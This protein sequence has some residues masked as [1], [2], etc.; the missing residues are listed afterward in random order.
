MTKMQYNHENGEQYAEI[1]LCN[2]RFVREQIN[3]MLDWIG[4]DN[5]SNEI[6]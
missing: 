5:P 3:S 6:G 4:V 1:T 2:V